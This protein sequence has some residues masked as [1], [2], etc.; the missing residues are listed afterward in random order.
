MSLYSS[1]R[2]PELFAYQSQPAVSVKYPLAMQKNLELATAFQRLEEGLPR[3]G[4]GSVGK[5]LNMDKNKWPPVGSGPV[6]ATVV[7][8]EALGDIRCAA[9]IQ[10]LVLKGIKDVDVVHSW[11][12]E[13]HKIKRPKSFNLGLCS[14][15]NRANKHC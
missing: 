2:T 10:P 3:K 4:S 9:F 13:W 11:K 14:S 12:S 1:G 7:P 8:Q 6:A 5:S 15:G